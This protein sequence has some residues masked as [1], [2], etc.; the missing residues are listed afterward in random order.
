MQQHE[1][2]EDG[3]DGQEENDEDEVDGLFDVNEDKV[4]EEEVLGDPIGSDSE[5]EQ[6]NIGTFFRVSESGRI[7]LQ[8]D[9]LRDLFWPAARSSNLADFN[10]A[11]KAIK[12]T[13]VKTVEYLLS[14]PLHYWSVHQFDHQTTSDHNTNNVVEAFNSWMI[15]HRA[16][17]LMIMMENVRRKFMK[18]LRK[19]YEDTL[20][21]PTDIPPAI[22]RQLQRNQT[23]ER[24]FDPLRCGEW[25]VKVVDGRRQFVIHLDKKTYECGLWVISG[26][27]CKHAI[28]CISKIRVDVE[29]YVHD[30]LKKPAY[31]RT[32][33]HYIHAIPDE[34]LWPEVESETVLPPKKRRRAGRPRLSRQRGAGEPARV[35]RSV[36]FRCSKCKQVGHN[37]RKCNTYETGRQRKRSRNGG[38]A[39]E[40]STAAGCLS[41]VAGPSSFAGPSNSAAPTITRV[42]WFPSNQQGTSSQGNASNEHFASQPLTPT[43]PQCSQPSED[44]DSAVETCRIFG[45]SRGALAQPAPPP[46]L[47]WLPR[48]CPDLHGYVNTNA[49][50]S[51]TSYTEFH[52]VGDPVNLIDKLGI[53]EVFLVGHDWVAMI[54]LVFL[55]VKAK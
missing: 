10:D 2:D 27:P 17:P 55:Y 30:Y 54:N 47:P 20:K 8:V 11:M 5:E 7:V 19:R 31:L 13:S 48:N 14:I 38:V 34:S 21:W 39:A 4:A 33:S 37:S 35:K 51:L 52:I 36:G 44:F 25:E 15:P 29:N 9:Y 24:Y 16:Q 53:E 1:S 45:G 28:A 49:P 46:L 6:P 3:V 41:I 22:R 50:P 32:Y 42:L 26:V 43:A 12:E 40:T 18:R 23:D